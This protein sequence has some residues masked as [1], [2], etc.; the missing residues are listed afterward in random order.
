MRALVLREATGPDGL[1]VEQVAEPTHDPSLVRIDVVAAGVTYPDLLTSQGRYQDRPD[2]PYVPGLEVAGIVRDAPADSTFRP[3]DRVAAACMGGGYAEV[4]VADPSLVM[5]I[6]DGMPFVQASGLVLN[7]QTMFFALHRRAALRSQELVV[8]RGAGG[9][10]GIAAIELSVAAGA[11]VLAVCRG[12]EKAALCRRAGAHHV[13]DEDEGE[14]FRDAVARVSG[15][16]GARLVVDPVGGDGTLDAL[17]SLAPEGRLL[18]LGFT[19]GIPSIPANR[20]LLRNIAVI[21]AA[22][23]AFLAVDPRIAEEARQR[24]EHLAASG[25]V[26]PPVHSVW[27]LE[28]GAEALIALRDRSLVGK[29]ALTVATG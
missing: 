26:R 10:L 5:G 9:G 16:I 4:A 11:E 17:R 8:V 29:A 28:R 23:G 21:G 3:G 13:V 27:P 25:A 15:G 18:V 20:L 6:P 12:A 24:I 14:L 22:W 1:R 19:G 2:L 7:Y